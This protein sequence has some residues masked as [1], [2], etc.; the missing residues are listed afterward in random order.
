MEQV[1]AK[2]R[3]K[4][5][6]DKEYFHIRND[7][8]RLK[9]RTPKPRPVVNQIRK[10]EMGGTQGTYDQTIL[11]AGIGSVHNGSVA[12]SRKTASRV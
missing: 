1:N 7:V 10:C 9:I 11:G 12:R 3:T 4:F 6:K 2:E 8:P 5:N